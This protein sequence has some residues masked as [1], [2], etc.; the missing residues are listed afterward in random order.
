[1]LTVK[2]IKQDGSEEL[3][4]CETVRYIPDD[5]SPAAFGEAGLYLDPEFPSAVAM[6]MADAA[7]GCSFMAKFAI[8]VSRAASSSDRCR[9]EAFVMNANG[10]T[11][12]RY[13]M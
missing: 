2:H 5:G 12:A 9:P 8:P 13:A 4:T 7:P 6:A 3:Y 10:A 1:M 11:V